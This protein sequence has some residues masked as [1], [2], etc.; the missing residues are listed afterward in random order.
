MKFVQLRCIDE[1]VVK[2]DPLKDGEHEVFGQVEHM[3]LL[4]LLVLVITTHSS[5]R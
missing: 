1:S 4:L 5:A 3:Q 2:I